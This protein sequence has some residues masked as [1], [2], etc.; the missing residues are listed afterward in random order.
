MEELNELEKAILSKLSVKYPAIQEH[1]PFLRVLNR[2]ITGVGMYVNFCY[3]KDPQVS[4]PC[5]EISDGCIS[6][7]ENIEIQ[8]LKY[9]IG[10]EVDVSDGKIKFIEFI[11]YGEEWDGVIKDYR[12]I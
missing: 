5:L 11:T 7:N 6:T 12:F 2:E 3:V 1:M 10:Y 9:G 4:I 8:G